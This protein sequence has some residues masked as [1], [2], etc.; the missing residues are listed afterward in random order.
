MNT[1]EQIRKELFALQD[2]EYHDFHC[3]LIP[4]VDPELVIGIRTPD[5]RKYARQLSKTPLA[6]EFLTILPH[7]YY[8]ENNLHGFLIEN[9][10]DY[11]AVIE[12]L[13]IFLPYVDNW[14]TC[15]MIS[16]KIFQKHLP[17]LL[18]KIKEWIASGHTY[19]IRFG[20][21][22]LM[23]FYLD[24]VFLPEYLEMAAAVNSEEY[25]VKMMVAWFFATALAKQYDTALTYLEKHRLDSW[26]HNKAIQKAIESYRITGEQ[27]EYLRTLKIK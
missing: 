24:E 5:L 18:D 17:A 9:M 27:K 11:P 1:E 12:A 23:K 19:T 25:Y 10:K 14:A 16:P 8:E 2:R 3:K 15:D 4:T 26:T 21:G 20:L 6:E 22:M 7:T 13:D